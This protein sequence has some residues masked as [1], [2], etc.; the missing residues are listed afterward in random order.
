LED[1]LEE[2]ARVLLLAHDRADVEEAADLGVLAQ[3]LEGGRG[4]E[5]GQEAE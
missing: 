1:A 2:I 3:G 5:R 4:G